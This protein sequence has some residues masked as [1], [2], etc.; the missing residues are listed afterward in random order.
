MYESSE[1][2]R[3]NNLLLPSLRP[4]LP[5]YLPAKLT[6]HSICNNK[7]LTKCKSLTR[8]LFTCVEVFLPDVIDCVACGTGIHWSDQP[9]HSHPRLKVLICQVRNVNRVLNLCCSPLKS[10]H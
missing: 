7:V 8:Y 6:N 1:N 5:S 4:S 2:C 9:I 3:L 10:D